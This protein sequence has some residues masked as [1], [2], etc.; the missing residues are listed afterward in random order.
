[1]EAS[2]GAQVAA[3]LQGKFGKD[4]GAVDMGGGQFFVPGPAGSDPSSA[5]SGVLPEVQAYLDAP[6]EYGFQK[7]RRRAV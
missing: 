6:I 4:R 2:A 1:M 7:L 5:G 3:L